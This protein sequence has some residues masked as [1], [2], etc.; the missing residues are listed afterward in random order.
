MVSSSGMIFNSGAIYVNQI[1]AAGGF[2]LSAISPAF[3]GYISPITMNVNFGGNAIVK[4]SNFTHLSSGFVEFNESAE[5]SSSNLGTFT[6]D[7]G[8]FVEVLDIEA[9]FSETAGRT[10]VGTS[11]PVIVGCNCPSI[12]SV[13][14]LSHNLNNKNRLSEFLDRNKYSLPSKLKLNYNAINDIWQQNYHYVGDSFVNNQIE[15]WNVLFDL[16]CSNSI[17]NFDYGIYLWKLGINLISSNIS[18]NNKLETRLLVGLPNLQ[19]CINSRLNIVLTINIKNMTITTT[20]GLDAEVLIL[21]DNLGIFKSNYWKQNPFLKINI[22]AGVVS[23]ARQTLNAETLILN[24]P[25]LT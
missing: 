7:S 6:I 24:E 12:S 13:L 4:S 8:V 18:T 14:T 25:L 20:S 10:M 23:E 1:V 11:T 5:I 17:G 16:Q 9:K 2:N 15:R 19:T 3:V 22:A 21:Y